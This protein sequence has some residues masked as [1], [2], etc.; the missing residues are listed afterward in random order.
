MHYLPLQVGF[1]DTIEIAYSQ[2]SYPG[3]CEVHRRRRAQPAHS[4]DEYPG[5]DQPLL[6]RF[7]NLGK[8]DMTAV[9]LSVLFIHGGSGALALK[10]RDH[11]AGFRSRRA[12][13][14]GDFMQV[15]PLQIM[16]TIDYIQEW[17]DVV[18]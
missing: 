9:A 17:L 3:G 1:V 14:D 7:A 2:A 6:T 8:L 11:R 16:V 5:F 13:R 18:G 12:G 15:P 10:C 4:N